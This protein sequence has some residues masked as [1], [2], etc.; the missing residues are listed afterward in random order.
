MG[1]T[2]NKGGLVVCADGKTTPGEEEERPAPGQE[3]QIVKGGAT[4]P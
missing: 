4:C 1:H 3:K 2:A